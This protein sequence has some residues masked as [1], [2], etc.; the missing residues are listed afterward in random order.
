MTEE[1]SYM[2]KEARQAQ[3]IVARGQV[4]AWLLIERSMYADK[5]Y[6]DGTAT[7]DQ[8]IEDMKSGNGLDDR[9]LDF[10]YNY[11]RQAKLLGLDTMQGR[12]ALG[13]AIS[14]LIH[15]LE[16]AITEHGPMPA[17][18]VSSTAGVQPWDEYP[19]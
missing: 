16:T 11:V 18:G 19:T 17:P 3:A 6:A 12:Q 5:K 7:R 15:Y 8:F 1:M 14:T 2:T 4:M 13:K 10:V 9:W